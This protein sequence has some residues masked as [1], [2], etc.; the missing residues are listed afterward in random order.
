MINCHY[1]ERMSDM[2]VSAF[3][4]FSVAVRLQAAERLSIARFDQ[5]FS[6]CFL[7]WC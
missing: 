4:A 5:L 3:T 6:L 1:Q 2:P 7:D